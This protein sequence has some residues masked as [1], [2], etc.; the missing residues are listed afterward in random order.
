MPIASSPAEPVLAVR[1]WRLVTPVRAGLLIALGLVTFHL[2][3]LD[4]YGLTI[5]SPSLFY[6]GD[7]T[8]FWLSHPR[9]PGAL[10]FLG[11]EPPGFTTLFERVPDPKD[12][13]H[14][15]VLPGFS[16]AVTSSLFHD[17]LG[18]V[19]GIPGHHIG[20]ILLN[21]LAVFLYCL[22]AC[23]L[24]GR[25]AGIAAAA[26]LALF[27]V[28]VGHAPTNAKDWPAA[29][30]YGLGVLAFGLG[31]VREQPRRMLEAALLL[32]VSLSCKMN[33]VFAVPTFLAWA[34][35]AWFALYF[36][37][38]AIPR[39]LVIGMAVA[40]LV[41]AIVFFIAWPW[42]WY[43]PVRGWSEHLVEYVNFTANYGVGPRSGW[44]SYSLRALAFM[45]PPLVLLAAAYYLATLPAQGREALAVGSLL[46]L[47]VGI[48]MLRIA[49]PRSNFYDASRHFIEYVPGL[50]AIGGSGLAGAV[51]RVQRWVEAGRSRV[52][53]ARRGWIAS[54]AFGVVWVSALTW[55]VAE[56]HPYQTTYFNVFIGGLGGA[57]QKALF[58]VP[59]PHD[60][61]VNGTEG[62]F[63][64][65]SLRDAGR[66][67]RQL[68]GPTD[69]VSVCGCPGPP[70]ARLNFKER[71]VARWVDWWEPEYH[72]AP[73][74]LLSPRETGCWWR[75]IREFESERPVVKRVERGG[76]L[77]YEI[78]GPK[79][80]QR[81]TPVSKVS[82][83]EAHPHPEDGVGMR[84][85][86]AR[87]VAAGRP[88]VRRVAPGGVILYDVLDPVS[89]EVVWA[90]T[91]SP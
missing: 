63:W 64:S 32:G 30:F 68:V 22:Y 1:C 33:A 20:L 56:Y 66:D 29:Q 70:L 84:L 34:P 13:L 36:R 80:G 6:A 5:D 83:Y 67:L 17:R 4:R 86:K 72:T 45:T 35:A 62:D 79:T 46:V 8:L 69:V 7:R 19:E 27:P 10:D 87:Q 12:P 88:V 44:T 61:R 25:Q 91:A 81:Y 3:S 57:Q 18:W 24:L 42:L 74:L 9:V 58:A 55:P 2:A 77:I 89:G 23:A 11:P 48:P 76:G 71:P 41:V 65:S 31:V 40:P 60:R 75:E 78:L 37:R 90:Q 15:P 85:E 28:A 39:R 26:A 38:R 82:W 14:Y 73:Y 16:G 43:G 49:L 47:W 50:C 59:W 21:G 53:D 52:L 54:I 51:R